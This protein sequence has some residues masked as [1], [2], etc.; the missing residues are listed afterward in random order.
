MQ[1]ISQ[2]DSACSQLDDNRADQP[3]GSLIQC[4]NLL[5]WFQRKSTKVGSSRFVSPDLSIS[6]LWRLEPRYLSRLFVGKGN[7]DVL[8]PLTGMCT[9]VLVSILRPL[10]QLCRLPRFQVC[11]CELESNGVECSTPI[12]WVA[13]TS[14][15]LFRSDITLMIILGRLS[16]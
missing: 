12:P 11:L 9:V 2:S 13:S 8:S 6:F 5:R 3:V 1:K 16:L 10:L 7:R 15:R 14:W 4:K